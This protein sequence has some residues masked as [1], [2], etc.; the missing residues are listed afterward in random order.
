MR[1]KITQYI[2]QKLGI[3]FQLAGDE[4]IFEKGLATSMF[5]LQLVIYLENEFGIEVENADLRLNHFN[6]IEHIEQFVSQKRLAT[7]KIACDVSRAG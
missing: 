7:G 2:I 6:T 5:S 3:D 4:D 1:E